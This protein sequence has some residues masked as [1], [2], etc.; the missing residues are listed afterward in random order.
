MDPRFLKALGHGVKALGL[1]LFRDGD[2]D[3]A[4][5]EDGDG[6]RGGSGASFAAAP[7]PKRRKR[8]ASSK[9]AGSCCTTP[10][11]SVPVLPPKRGG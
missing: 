10:A 7:R 11:R 4:E 2:D 8:R 1:A 5:N 3:E 9:P 6:D